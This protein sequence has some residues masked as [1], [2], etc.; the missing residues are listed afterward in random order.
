MRLVLVVGITMLLYPVAA[1]SQDRLDNAAP[2]QQPSAKTDT[3]PPQDKSSILGAKSAAAIISARKPRG[4]VGINPLE[5]QDTRIANRVE[6]RIRNRIDRY[7]DPLANAESPFKVANERTT[8]GS[9]Q[10]R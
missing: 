7:Y 10:S 8:R 3:P 6:S 4:E 1:L 2:P 5:R 9:S